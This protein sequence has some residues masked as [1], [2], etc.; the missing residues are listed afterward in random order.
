MD[1]QKKAQWLDYPKAGADD[2]LEEDELKYDYILHAEQNALLW[3]NPQGVRLNTHSKMVTTKMPCDECS[4]ILYD[5]GISTVVTNIQLPK[6]PDDPSRLKGLTYEK[7]H[8]LMENIST[9]DK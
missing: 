5:C 2:S 3:R 8:T 4:P 6:S 1:I 7:I 9:F